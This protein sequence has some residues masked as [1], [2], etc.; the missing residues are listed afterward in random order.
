MICSSCGTANEV[1]RKFCGE[2]GTGLESGCPSCGT[3]NAP[4]TKFCG[5]CGTRLDGSSSTATAPARPS[6]S[7]AAVATGASGP[8]GAHA[9][10]RRLVSILFADLVG[11]TARSDGTD[12]EQVREFL[13]D[14]F[15]VARQV[16]ER[17]GGTVEKFIGDAVMAI[18]GAPVAQEDDAERAVRAA[19]DLVEAVRHLGRQ[20]GDSELAL[21]AGVLTGEAAVAVGAVGQGMVA[22]DLVNTASR[23]QSVA[24]PGSVLVGESTR[25]AAAAS[26]LFEE[27]GEQLLKGKAAPVS[28][29]RALRVRKLV[30]TEPTEGVESPFV[31][32]DDELRLL[33]DFLHASS[34]ERRVRLISVTG[35]GGIGKSRLAWELRKY[36]DGISEV[37]YVHIGR[38]PS[39]GDGVTFWALGEMARM[40]A[41]LAEGDDE[42]TTRERITAT[43]AQYVADEAERR[44]IEPALLSLLGVG[45][46][47]TGGRDA[48]FAAWRVFFEQVSLQ[49]TTLLVFEDLQWADAG[50]LDFIDHVLEWSIGYPILI[51]S[52]A[53]PELLEKRPTFGAGRRNF[54]ALALGPLSDDAMREMLTGLVPG[55]PPATVRA[56]LERADG[57]PLYAVETIRMLVEDGR[58]A[59]ADGVYR[60]VGEL[61]E[62]HIP[63]T[64]HALI[65]ARLDA[66][67]PADRAL[68]QDGAVLG[69]TFTVA[70]L[71]ALTAEDP[72]ALE[73]RLRGLV[74]RELLV[75]D[76]DPRSP[77]RGQFG[78]T[79][80]LVREVAYGTLSKKDRR[81]RHLAAARYFEAL[82]DEEVA[83]VLATHYVSAYEAAP[84]GD[85]ADALAAQ[86]RIALRAAAERARSLGSQE[87][88]I[89]YWERARTVTVDA[90]EEAE[91]LERIG[92]AERDTGRYE[93]AES[94]FREA[95][96]RWA[97]LG[98]RLASAR[99]TLGL[100]RTMAFT[101]RLTEALPITRAA[102]E[103]V[104]DLAPDPVVAELWLGLGSGT[105]QLGDREGAIHWIDKALSDAERLRAMPLIAQAMTTKGGFLSTIGRPVEGRALLEAGLRLAESIGDGVTATR[106]AHHLSLA[107]MDD[108]PRAALK[109]TRQAFDLANRYGLAPLRLSALGNAIEASLSVGDW[110]WLVDELGTTRVEELE[111]ADRWAILIGTIE[112]E[113]ILG[114]DVT[115]PEAALRSIA[116][117]ST[118]PQATAAT[119]LAVGLTRMAEGRWEDAYR[120]VLATEQDDLNAPYGLMVAARAA[121][122]M[123]DAERSR[124]VLDRLDA[125]G[126]RGAAGRA[127]RDG[128][129]AALAMLDGDAA[130]AH[131][132]FRDA[133]G[134]MR[135]LGIEL[136]LAMSQLDYLA[137]APSADALA[138]DAA[139]EAREILERTGAIAYLRQLDELEAERGASAS[140][141]V[142]TDAV[143]TSGA[144][145]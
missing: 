1:G 89:A 99:A 55:L 85:E 54:V 119:A 7:P 112:I 41:G 92:T 60:P 27:A 23:L 18:W 111:S 136:A 15:D 90:A 97:G 34:R 58:L 4:G 50:L 78:F 39:F 105:G 96:D 94:H 101:G 24:P 114:R 33:K 19:L 42:A 40:R 36:I 121:I 68:L 21:R 115:E 75:L 138:G 125:R 64:L 52:L 80:A 35:Q 124:E 56:I 20:T 129:I 98:D 76:T 141:P 16:V 86:A 91:L 57:I 22:G 100:T 104:A 43:L 5:E 6:R 67:D 117:T 37:I 132:G 11:F 51:V 102:A 63:E 145:V 81:D 93:A 53:R 103:S 83:G 116:G 109:V 95:I 130:T 140:A 31:G 113:S 65:A 88:A 45:E 123:G 71:A 134:R 135:D 49:G 142:T 13:S 47:P 87:S 106:A 144:A 26:I 8:A 28:A 29:W 77:E 38:S 110:G 139:V 66:V 25:R 143:E 12:P 32:R 46:A 9:T 59:V 82:E 48:L 73:A 10:E 122:R 17:Y 126:A 72:T 69:Q 128:L 131:A 62:L 74:Q 70:S 137:V 107:L 108:D 84:K 30:G 14:Y 120:E 79:Q 118:D 44:R 2:C 133:W 127:I 61:G 3:Q